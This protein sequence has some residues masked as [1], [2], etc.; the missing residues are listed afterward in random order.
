MY[1]KLMEEICLEAEMNSKHYK[2]IELDKDQE[3]HFLKE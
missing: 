3:V 2:E 1:H